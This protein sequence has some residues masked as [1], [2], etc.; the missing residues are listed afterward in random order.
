ML[1]LNKQNCEKKKDKIQYFKG[2]VPFQFNHYVNWVKR[3][4]YLQ[5]IGAWNDVKQQE[6]IVKQGIRDTMPDSDVY[7]D[8]VLRKWVADNPQFQDCVEEYE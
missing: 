5:S 7:L 6:D 8:N 2:F 3:R 4:E 1:R